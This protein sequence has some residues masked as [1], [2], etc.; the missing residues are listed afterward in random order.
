M[1]TYE[2]MIPRGW[3]RLANVR[4]E[5]M[6]DSFIYLGAS[7]GQTK[8]DDYRLDAPFAGFIKNSA[9]AYMKVALTL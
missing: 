2:R 8:Y 4:Y 3:S 9:T 7:S 1:D 6:P 5:F